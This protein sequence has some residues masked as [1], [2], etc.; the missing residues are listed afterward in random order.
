L[1]VTSR[2][3]LGVYGERQRFVR[4][5]TIPSLP[6]P[7]APDRVRI[8]DAVELFIQRATAVNQHFDVTEQNASAVAEICRQL[9]G[10][11][12]ALETAAMRCKLVSPQALLD[13]LGRDVLACAS[14]PRNPVA[15]QETLREALMSSYRRLGETEQLL[16]SRLAVFSASF[17]PCAATI[18][19]VG[20]EGETM[21]ALRALVDASLVQYETWPSGEPRCRMLRLVRELARELLANRAEVE[22]MHRRHANYFRTL[23]GMDAPKQ[24][25][26]YPEAVPDQAK[27]AMTPCRS[28]D[29]LMLET[30]TP[31]RG[32]A[33]GGSSA[34]ADPWAG[35]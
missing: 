11:P 31:G 20:G 25:A 16:F 23:T 30:A 12:L 1:L 13:E 28:V 26:A 19:G 22:M 4:P 29:R 34:D 5:L 9:D 17:A 35:R 2:Q 3:V 33:I 7:L 27:S 6:I 14:S 21:R 24:G 32:T 8:Y 15:R 10:L 18:C